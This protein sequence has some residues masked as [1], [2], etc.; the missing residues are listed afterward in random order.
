MIFQGEVADAERYEQYKAAAA[1]SVEAAGGRYLV[2]GGPAEALDGGAPPGRT[3]VIEFPDQASAL[4][5]YNGHVYA[6]AR[7]LRLEAAQGRMYVV[8]GV[9]GS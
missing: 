3:V 8:E 4:A 1:G 5:W 2:R 9:Q 6:S 7:Q